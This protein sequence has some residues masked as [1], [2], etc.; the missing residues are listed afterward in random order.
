MVLEYFD[1]IPTYGSDSERAQDINSGAMVVVYEASLAAAGKVIEL[2]RKEGLGAVALEQPDSIMVHRFYMTAFVR[3]AVPRD[4]APLAESLL[5]NWEDNS[6][7]NVRGLTAR[8][9]THALYSCV[10]TALVALCLLVFGYLTAES[11]ILLVGVWVA[12]FALLAN[13]N[14]ISRCFKKD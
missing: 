12:A 8:L 5:R 2:L 11:V 7:Q 10:I 14:R 1:P 13:A 4:Q 3:I 6:R 9:K